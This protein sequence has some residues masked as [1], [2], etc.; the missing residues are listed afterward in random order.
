MCRLY[1]YGVNNS[2]FQIFIGELQSLRVFFSSF[3][4]SVYNNILRPIE[5]DF[6]P[7]NEFLRREEGHRTSVGVYG[8]H[9]LAG[10]TC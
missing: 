10:R 8:D 3:V 5:S 4:G 1:M 9:V 2:I 6:V 7:D